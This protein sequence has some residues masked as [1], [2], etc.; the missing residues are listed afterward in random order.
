MVES[1]RS[2]GLKKTE[3]IIRCSMLDVRCS[4][5]IS[6]FSLIWLDA[7]GQRQR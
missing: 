1:V 3:Y 5:L 4:T 7:R 6:F 2:I